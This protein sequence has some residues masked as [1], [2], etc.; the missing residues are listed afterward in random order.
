MHIKGKGVMSTYFLDLPE[1]VSILNVLN[2]DS[3][4]R[5]RISLRGDSELEPHLLLRNFSLPY[6]F[7]RRT[8][9][10]SDDSL[11]AHNNNYNDGYHYKCIVYLCKPFA[12]IMMG[13]STIED[14]TALV[15]PV[16][17]DPELGMVV[18]PPPKRDPMGMAF[19][20]ASSL[21]SWDFDVQ[22]IISK[23]MLID[24]A[25]MLFKTSCLC[26]PLGVSETTLRN[27]IENVAESY[28]RRSFHNLQ[29]AVSVLHITS[30][31]IGYCN[32]K[33]QETLK[34]H[35]TLS[36]VSRFA[37]M[38]GALV[39]DCDHPGHTNS[40]EVNTNSTL[41]QQ[42][43]N[44]FVLEH[45]HLAIAESILAKPGCNIL[46]TFDEET[47]TRFRDLLKYIVFGTDMSVHKE[48]VSEVEGF[49]TELDTTC[50]A[51]KF[52]LCRALLH[53]ADLSNP[54]KAFDVSK[55]WAI[56]LADEHTEQVQAEAAFGLTSAQFMVHKDT[57]SVYKGEIYFLTHVAQPLWAAM[58]KTWPQLSGLHEQLQLNIQKYQDLIIKASEDESRF[59]TL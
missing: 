19:V 35:G 34:R 36:L 50:P 1:D 4:P 9:T 6:S 59:S 14:S 41:F 47:A 30:L 33:Q 27:F 42:Y 53:T 51:S 16:N 15:L 28:H 38:V 44:D 49:E 39:H 55:A 26:G 5:R 32:Q 21:L 37:L 52:A 40:F 43:G 10:E 31:L 54:V 22:N 45:H 24:I 18:T 56:R 58:A 8:R 17:D 57:L 3:N 46:E 29:H 2:R 13:E 48:I 7:M 12:A 23:D 11:H 25:F 20:V